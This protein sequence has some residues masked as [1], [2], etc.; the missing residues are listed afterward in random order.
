[1]STQSTIETCAVGSLCQR[2][3][4]SIE[5]H[6]NIFTAAGRM[7]EAHVGCLFVT[8]PLAGSDSGKVVG[9]LTDRDIVVSVV[10]RK[11][12]P[13]SLKVVDVMS[14][15]PLMVS[16][17]T[18]VDAALSFMQDAGVRRVAV[19]G[20]RG[21]L[22]GIV[23]LDDVLQRLSEQIGKICG[24]IRNEVRTERLMRP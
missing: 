22:V 20:R 1:M 8:E 4:I 12:D 5:A 14:R 6:E 23:S 24:S 15:N 16:E 13:G 3:V 18:S 17:D 10:A 11:A 19:T 9:T 2:N 7:R 21:E